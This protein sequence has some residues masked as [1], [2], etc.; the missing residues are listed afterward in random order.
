MVTALNIKNKN[1]TYVLVKKKPLGRNTDNSWIYVQKPV[2]AVYDFIKFLVVSGQYYREYLDRSLEWIYRQ[3]DSPPPRST[4]EK[5]DLSK[6]TVQPKIGSHHKTGLQLS[7]CLT[8]NY[9]FIFNTT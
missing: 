1:K 9:G 8:K 3:N 7:H 5:V 4:P 2:T 6:D